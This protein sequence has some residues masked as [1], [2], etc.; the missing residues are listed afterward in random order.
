MKTA[1]EDTIISYDTE[2]KNQE[3]IEERIG[4]I[5]VLRLTRN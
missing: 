1:L 2:A 5:K 4:E 3:L